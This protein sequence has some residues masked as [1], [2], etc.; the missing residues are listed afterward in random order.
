[1]TLFGNIFRAII[2]ALGI[3]LLGFVFIAFGIFS[4]I[5]NLNYTLGSVALLIG[6]AVTVA[7]FIVFVRRLMNP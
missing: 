4:R 5:K 3:Y 1:M 2:A 7:S 6:T